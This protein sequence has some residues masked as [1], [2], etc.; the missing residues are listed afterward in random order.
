MKTNLYKLLFITT[1]LL[2]AVPP[3]FR[4]LY[5]EREQFIAYIFSFTL[6]IILRVIKSRRKEHINLNANIDYTL[7]ALVI[8]YVIS[9]FVAVNKRLAMSELLKYYHY[10]IIYLLIKE[11]I[12]D[13]KQI[14]IIIN[15][16]L[17]SITGVSL[18]GLGAAAGTITYNG[19]YS[20]GE[21][22]INSTIQ[23]HNA[24][25]ALVMCGLFL[26]FSLY[27]IANKKWLKTIYSNCGYMLLLGFILSYSRGS[28]IV[29]PI[30]FAIFL[31]ITWKKSLKEIIIFTISI[32]LPILISIQ[33]FNQAMI[34]RKEISAWGWLIIGVIIT[35]LLNLLLQFINSKIK[36]I[37]I[38]L[39]A[40]YIVIGST[41]GLLLL[42][43]FIAP[44]IVLHFIPQELLERLR[45]ISFTTQTVQERFV[46]YYDALKIVKDYPLIG[47]GGGAWP[48]LYFMYQSYMY[49]SKQAHSYFMQI[50]VE[51]GTIGII[52]FAAVLISFLYTAIINI[53]GY[54]KEKENYLLQ[55]GIFTAASSLI[56]HSFIDFDL[57]ISAI[58]IVLWSL[59][60]LTAT[61]KK[62]NEQKT[63]KI[64]GVYI[65]VP[66]VI[67]LLLTST[68]AIA[69]NYAK[70]GM[71]AKAVRFDPIN[72]SY[73]M[74]YGN[75]LYDSLSDIER[76]DKKSIESAKK[77]VDIALQLEPYN[78]KMNVYGATF[79]FKTGEIPKALALVDK[80]VE[81]Q[82]LR[83][84]NYQQKAQA[85]LQA[86][87]AYLNIGQRDKAKEL[88]QEVI[89][90]ENSISALNV[91]ILKP[92]E[93]TTQTKAMIE[94]AKGV[95]PQI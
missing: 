4:G 43:S 19:A 80:S 51:T 39:K 79:Y 55:T 89:Q 71:L 84:E 63:I 33:G 87:Q 73:R 95:L 74:D 16:L 17:L 25:G 94:H 6:F 92:I 45:D 30:V 18:V 69:T 37:I 57:S 72:A 35:T 70:N 36:R 3:Y 42:T 66:T 8:V 68:F 52:I 75:I 38:K 29:F 15:I 86:T 22:W 14:K 81:V 76:R 60:A 78:S 65:L 7:I 5:F 91:N 21:K 11:Q 48:S 44:N 13:I 93:L 34:Q 40:L 20:V 32:M 90:I 23:Y 83:P 50:W 59:Y 82:P 54:S 85:Y 88:V 27:S 9:T 64:S 67:L 62:E 77:Q 31:I 28:W 41:L 46:F 12:K 58:S 61:L 56:I 53:K 47:A 26:C 2:I 1:C 49:W 24:F 10:F